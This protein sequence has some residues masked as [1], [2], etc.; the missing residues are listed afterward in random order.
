MALFEMFISIYKE[1]CLEKSSK[2]H[3]V[4]TRVANHSPFTSCLADDV[5]KKKALKTWGILKY[6]DGILKM[7]R[8]QV[9]KTKALR[10]Y[11]TIFSF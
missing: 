6:H 1:S 10:L 4:L 11:T 5:L 9:F 8:G 2:N 3:D 7:S